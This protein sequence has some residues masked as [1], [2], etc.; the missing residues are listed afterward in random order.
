MFARHREWDDDPLRADPDQGPHRPAAVLSRI[1]PASMPP[2]PIR[3]AD[4]TMSDALAST[5]AWPPATTAACTAAACPSRWCS[6]ATAGSAGPSSSSAR[7]GRLR[8]ARA[9]RSTG[10]APS[11]PTPAR[12]AWCTQEW[13]GNGAAARRSSAPRRITALRGLRPAAPARQR[14]PRRREVVERRARRAVAVRRRPEVL[15]TTCPPGTR[16]DQ[17]RSAR[18]CRRSP[19]LQVTEPARVLDM[20]GNGVCDADEHRSTCCRTAHAPIVS[21][22][23]ACAPATA[24]RC[25]AVL[26]P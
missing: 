14:P 11:S 23:R 15:P 10:S 20:C 7:R 8:G 18:G 16:L 3:L 17:W 4:R 9:P 19:R 6:T 12:R 26:Q 2:A 22:A 5:L 24:P 21:Y 25:R 13:P 1:M